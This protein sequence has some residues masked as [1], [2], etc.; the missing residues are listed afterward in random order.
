MEGKMM[1][2]SDVPCTGTAISSKY[3]GNPD[4]PLWDSARNHIKLFQ[5]GEE[6]SV[7][8][9]VLCRKHAL[10]SQWD[11]VQMEL[12]SLDA[13]TQSPFPRACR[14]DRE[15]A[16][17]PLGH[18]ATGS[19]MGVPEQLTWTKAHFLHRS[20]GC[21]WRIADCLELLR[22]HPLVI[23]QWNG[24]HHFPLKRSICWAAEESSKM[25]QELAQKQQE[26]RSR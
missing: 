8:L 5:E 12:L 11:T 24:T 15:G 16:K 14:S 10:V 3:P 13:A 26:C 9:R 19:R 22:Q 23:L 21:S 25:K 7:L 17:S 1:T 18:K 2:N 20:A 4:L 6:M